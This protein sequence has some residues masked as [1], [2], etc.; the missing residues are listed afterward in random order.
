M[1]V[2]VVTAVDVVLNAEGVLE[3][4]LAGTGKDEVDGGGGSVGDRTI[5]CKGTHGDGVTDDVG[6]V[7]RYRGW[8]GG[9]GRCREC[10][11]RCLWDPGKKHLKGGFPAIWVL[12]TSVWGSYGRPDD[13]T[14]APESIVDRT[15]PPRRPKVLIAIRKLAY[16]GERNWRATLFGACHGACGGPVGVDSGAALGARGKDGGEPDYMLENVSAAILRKRVILQE[17]V[18]F[19]YKAAPL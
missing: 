2:R 14:E 4:W 15:A 19:Q 18:R 3:S 8:K 17:L 11:S 5:Y 6:V 9:H 1:C 16:F 10:G 7:G 13:A 12:A